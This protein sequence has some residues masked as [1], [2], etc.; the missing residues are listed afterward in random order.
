MSVAHD[1]ESKTNSV[2]SRVSEAE[3][4]ARIDLAALYRLV[5]RHGWDDLVFTHISLR[6]PGEDEHFLINPYGMLFDEITASSLVKVD[7]DGNIVMETDHFINPAGFTVHSPFHRASRDAN[8][9]IHLHSDCGVAVAAQKDGLL[10]ISQHALTLINDLA[11]HDYEGIALDHAECDRLLADMGDKHV[12]ILR[13][14]GTL[15][16][17]KTPA[18]AYLRMFFLERACKIQIMAQAGGDL[19]HCDQAMQDKV[20]EQAAMAFSGPGGEL[21]WPSLLRA[22]DRV[23]PS[24]RE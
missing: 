12:M 8:C 6:V 4:Q 2:Q 9:I 19:I 24:Y 7:L 10:P 15:A 18:D 16:V 5:A 13:N 23:D 21:V 14:H 1:V 22:L 17:G 3:W 11:Y 20:G